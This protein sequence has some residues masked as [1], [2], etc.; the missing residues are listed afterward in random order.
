[1]HA[2]YAP[3]QSET[4]PVPEH[5]CPS[6]A[7]MYSVTKRA[8]GKG[9]QL[10]VAY[11]VVYLQVGRSDQVLAAGG[12]VALYTCENVF[13]RPGYDT[14]LGAFPF[15][16]HCERLPSSRLPVCNDGGIVSL[17]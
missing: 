7:S 10:Q 8:A 15:S 17:Q 13:H 12:C 9:D 3:Y 14:P 5:S 6:H 1:M 4:L 11:L 16:L 2:S